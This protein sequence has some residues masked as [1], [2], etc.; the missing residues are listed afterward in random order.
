M[1]LQ[2]QLKL[3]DFYCRHNKYNQKIGQTWDSNR[4][5]NDDGDGG[6]LTNYAVAYI[7][8]YKPEMMVVYIRKIVSFIQSILYYTTMGSNLNVIATG[9]FGF[10]IAK[11]KNLVTLGI[12]THSKK[13]MVVEDAYA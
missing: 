1:R 12:R 6:Y 3:D 10:R 13:M 2:N 5:Q 4:K 9:W 8:K 7:I 11:K